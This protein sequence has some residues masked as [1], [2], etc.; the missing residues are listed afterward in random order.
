[1]KGMDVGL[2]SLSNLIL[3]TVII[4]QIKVIGNLP[5]CLKLWL[6]LFITGGYDCMLH[7]PVLCTMKVWGF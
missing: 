2:R 4:M 1:M 3:L 5:Y 7:M 6:V